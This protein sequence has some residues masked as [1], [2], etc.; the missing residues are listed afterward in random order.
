MKPAKAFMWATA[1]CYFAA[2][3]AALLGYP[4]EGSLPPIHQAALYLLL[5]IAL[6]TLIF[7]GKSR[8]L[9]FILSALYGV[10]AGLSFSG[11]QKWINYNGSSDYLGVAMA[12]WDLA[13]AV[14][15]MM[16]TFLEDDV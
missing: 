1:W 16:N 13:L 10:L 11:I 5:G 9:R 4:A 8:V 7:R 2:S 12:A 15:I 6:M 14:A 3:L